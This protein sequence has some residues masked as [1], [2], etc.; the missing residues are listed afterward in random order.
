MSIQKENLK[1]KPKNFGVTLIQ[2]AE[3]KTLRLLQNLWFHPTP[4]SVGFKEDLLG[5]P[6]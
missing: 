3:A 1:S 2:A 4:F 5:G 6:Y